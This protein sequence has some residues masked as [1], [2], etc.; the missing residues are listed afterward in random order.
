MSQTSID[1]DFRDIELGLARIG[2][3]EA[4][5]SMRTGLPS[6]S[7][8]T[9][10]EAIGF[11]SFESIERWFAWHDGIEGGPLGAI[12]I[13]PGFYQLSLAEAV[14]N[15]E[16]FRVDARW[17]RDWF[18]V[19]ADGGGYFYVLDFASKQSVP[20]RLFRNDWVEHIVEYASLESFVS[21]LAEAYRQGII[22]SHP[23]G[24]LSMNATA[25]ANVAR[26]R[27]PEV[28]WWR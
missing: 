8:R 25:Y 26:E 18:P 12:S 11:Q 22:E 17:D 23:G 13:Y 19:L 6:K 21:T 24:Y 15:Y 1:E 28:E 14:V 2:R 27:N 10:M 3:A 4:V 7:V 20:V 16:A 9:G 5:K